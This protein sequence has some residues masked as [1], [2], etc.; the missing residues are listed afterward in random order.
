MALTLLL[1]AVGLIPRAHRSLVVGRL[2]GLVVPQV[3]HWHLHGDHLAR[4][5]RAKGEGGEVWDVGWYGTV[6]VWLSLPSLELHNDAKT[7]L[8]AA[9]K[10]NE[11]HSFLA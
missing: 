3:A 11:T 9:P 7:T 10:L 1:I 8:E 6:G 2:V 4:W 5:V